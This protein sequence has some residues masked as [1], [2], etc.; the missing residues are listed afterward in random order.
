MTTDAEVDSRVE[1]IP[2][3]VWLS[4]RWHRA[5]EWAW[6][7]VHRH[8]HDYVKQHPGYKRCECGARLVW[9]P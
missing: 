1:R 8:E 9:L 4:R 2:L 3:R 7:I 5:L 6:R